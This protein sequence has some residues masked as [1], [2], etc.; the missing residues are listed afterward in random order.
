MKKN[1]KN[2][3]PTWGVVTISVI[4]TLI[5]VILIWDVME[6]DKK[7]NWEKDWDKAMTKMETVMKND[8]EGKKVKAGTNA[9][10]TPT[11]STV[12]TTAATTT[13]TVITVTELEDWLDNWQAVNCT[14]TNMD[15]GASTW[16]ETSMNF[17]QVRF[18]NANGGLIVNGNWTYIWDNQTMTGVQ[19]QVDVSDVQESLIENLPMSNNNGYEIVCESATSVDTT[20]PAN[21]DFNEMIAVN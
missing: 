13:E 9:S 2:Q 4:V 11:P 15:T 21:V 12:P 18:E 8:W 17:E 10:P 7:M 3:L 5:V 16:Y 20:L 6:K 1:D 14:I 19:V